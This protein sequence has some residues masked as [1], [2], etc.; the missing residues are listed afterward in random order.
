[1]T[2][3]NN[4]DETVLEGSGNVFADLGLQMSD[5]DMLKVVIAR[6]ITRIVHAGGYTQQAAAKI[7]KTDQPKVSRLLRGRLK[8]FASKWLIERLLLLGYDLEINVKKASRQ[9]GRIKLAA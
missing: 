9:R 5:D 1:M 3:R 8:D 4:D 2:S 6:A 7:M